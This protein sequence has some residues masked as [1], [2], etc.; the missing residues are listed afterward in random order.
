MPGTNGQKH[1]GC[2]KV[3][4]E[5]WSLKEDHFDFFVGREQYYLTLDKALGEIEQID[6][7]IKSCQTQDFNVPSPK[8][9][10]VHSHHFIQ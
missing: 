4:D 3:D 9:L 2:V 10:H 5:G 8:K 6:Y 7:E 1:N